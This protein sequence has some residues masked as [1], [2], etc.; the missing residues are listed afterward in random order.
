MIL[1]LQATENSMIFVTNTTMFGIIVNVYW[2]AILKQRNNWFDGRLAHTLLAMLIDTSWCGM[3]VDDI[4]FECSN[5]ARNA[6]CYRCPELPFGMSTLGIFQCKHKH[7]WPWFFCVFHVKGEGEKQ[8]GR[9]VRSD[10]TKLKCLPRSLHF[11]M[12]INIPI[13]ILVTTHRAVVHGRLKQLVDSCTWK[14]FEVRREISISSTIADYSL[15]CW[16]YQKILFVWGVGLWSCVNC[17]HLES[18]RAPRPNKFAN[19]KL[20]ICFSSFAKQT[21]G[22]LIQQQFGIHWG[23]W[24]NLEALWGR[25]VDAQNEIAFLI[26]VWLF[27][28]GQEDHK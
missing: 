2:Y 18:S 23:H 26:P 4:P 7:L 5:V 15:T 19:P 14:P 3:I 10:P 13:W 17:G 16:V 24:D 11:N 8:L 21:Y 9:I 1:L 20:A 22:S 28:N 6:Y 12:F 25:Q 27:A